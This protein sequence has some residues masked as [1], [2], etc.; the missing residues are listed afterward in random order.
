MLA[1]LAC[2]GVILGHS[3]RRHVLGET[4]SLINRKM[5]AA[6]KAGLRVVLCIGETL[7]E[8]KT[9]RMEA[10]LRTQLDSGLAGV[11]KA[12]LGQVILAYEP[13]WAIGTGLNATPQQAQE[14]HEY[15]RLRVSAPYGEEAAARIPIV[16]GGSVKPENAASLL[17]EPDI[18]G[19]LIGGASLKADQFLSIY[20]SA[21]QLV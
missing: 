3:E 13:V 8:R 18:D 5:L 9:N 6:L 2:S 11:E 21:L 4:D 16:Y 10:V 15:L 1:D 20:R 17:G 19:C 7:E 12:S 14:V